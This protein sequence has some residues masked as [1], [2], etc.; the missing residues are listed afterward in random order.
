MQLWAL[1]SGSSGN[2][3]L[4]ESERTR[5]LV[6]CGRPLAQVE[7]YLAHCGVSPEE[8]DGIVL[9]HAH[10]DHSR[11]ARDLSDLYQV[12]VYA[13]RGTLSCQSLRDSA[14]A[15]PID[16]DRPVTIG[17]IAVLPF[18]VP[19]DCFEPVG[20]RFEADS[21]RAAITTDLGWVPESAQTQLA[22]LDL[23]VIEANYDPELLSL[24]P[25][26]PFL[27]RRVAGRRGHLSNTAAAQAISACRDRAPG[28]VWLAHLSENS[29]TADHALRTV[30]KHLRR[31]GLGH[32]PVRVARH[33]QPSL[34]WNSATE[35]VK[36]LPLF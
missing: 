20:F 33:R 27:K 10:G 25:Y 11:S 1:A 22:D 19:H 18:A 15:R 4:L 23:L 21:G 14:L 6:E 24:A 12:P 9:T 36:Q 5:L 3:F 32:I 28:A 30:G 13:S 17:E 8:L 29:N 35:T 2:C 7:R 16:A 31:H 26:P 34:Y